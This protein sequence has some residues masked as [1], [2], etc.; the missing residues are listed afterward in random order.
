ML[1]YDSV[2][3]TD[4]TISYRDENVT[5]QQKYNHE[6]KGAFNALDVCKKLYIE[7]KCIV[8]PIKGDGMAPETNSEYAVLAIKGDGMAPETNSEYAM[9][10]LVWENLHKEP[11][12]KFDR[13]T[14]TFV[15]IKN[16][17]KHHEIL[18]NFAK[19]NSKNFRLCYSSD[20]FGF[21]NILPT[22]HKFYESIF[23]QN[24]EVKLEFYCKDNEV[25]QKIQKNITK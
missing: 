8:S 5:V 16:F 11:N 12:I 23:E 24:A 10:D 15:D 1:S 6:Q 4:K 22:L 2:L 21:D 14:L 17:E 9:T 25:I 18:A 13:A 3:I 20:L 19:V 7:T